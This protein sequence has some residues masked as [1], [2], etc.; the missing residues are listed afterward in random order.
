MCKPSKSA[1][2]CPKFLD[3]SPMALSVLFRFSFPHSLS[4]GS[5][6]GLHGALGIR[7]SWNEGNPLEAH[8]N[9]DDDWGTPISGNPHIYIYIY[10]YIYII[11][12]ACSVA[13][14][15]WAA[16]SKS[17]PPTSATCPC[18]CARVIRLRWLHILTRPRREC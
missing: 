14:T 1:F 5:R 11:K 2:V 6:H 10:I 17:Q 13:C 3:K 7:V 18:L 4:L 15:W 8:Q 16:V 9:M 12:Y